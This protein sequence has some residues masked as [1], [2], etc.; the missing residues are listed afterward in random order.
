MIPYK[1]QVTTAYVLDDPRDL[2]H[3]YVGVTEG[4]E[5]ARFYNHCNVKEKTARKSPCHA[6]IFGL[7]K[8]NLK[9]IM[10]V[11]ER[12]PI[13]SFSVT[14]VEDYWIGF[15]RAQGAPLLNVRAGGMWGK[16]DKRFMSYEIEELLNGRRIDGVGLKDGFAPTE[17]KF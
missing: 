12:V 14:E 2:S 16:F 9:P 3:H 11:L 1:P 6:W 17:N 5:K 7:A 13:T 10:K 8:F 15:F 4:C